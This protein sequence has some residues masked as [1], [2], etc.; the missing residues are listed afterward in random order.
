M[1]VSNS[2]DSPVAPVDVSPEDEDED[3]VKQDHQDAAEAHISNL[4]AMLESICVLCEGNESCTA[5]GL[6]DFSVIIERLCERGIAFCQEAY[7]EVRLMGGDHG[8]A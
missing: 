5:L 8:Q 2:T 3:D 4:Q 1:A 6:E 7:K